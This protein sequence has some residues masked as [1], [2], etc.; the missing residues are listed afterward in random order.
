MKP[1]LK[2]ILSLIILVACCAIADCLIGVILDKM[3]DRVPNDGNEIG[4]AHFAIKKVNDPVLI[5]GSSRARDH[6][7]PG[8]I[9]DSL[10]LSTYNFGRQGH[11]VSYASSLVS[12]ILDRYT[13]NLVIW[14]LGMDTLFTDTDEDRSSTLKP[15]YWNSSIVQ[16]VIDEKEG[17]EARIKLMSNSYRYNGM[18]IDI[19][20]S[21]LRGGIDADPNKG[22]TPIKHNTYDIEPE[23]RLDHSFNGDIDQARVNR[24]HNALQRLTDAGVKVIVFD[25]PH[26]ALPNPDRNLASETIIRKECERLSIPIFDNRYLD[27]FLQRK[28]L[29]RD[30]SHLFEDG[31]EIYTQIAAHQIVQ[32]YRR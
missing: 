7:Y 2:F 9:S 24:L 15:Y 1:F 31:A 4:A 10:S 6:Y 5:I 27:F 17:K 14:E 13:P 23:L 12:M 32:E 16:E 29:F 20:Y 28:E 22:M 26:Y 21:F 25:S 30:N 18:A 19:V 8:I 11:Y 3:I